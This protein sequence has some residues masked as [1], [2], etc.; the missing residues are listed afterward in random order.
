MGKLLQRVA[1][2]VFSA[3]FFIGCSYFSNLGVPG[4]GSWAERTL[5]QLTLREKIAQ[6][7]VY[8]MNLRFMNA[9]SDQW[10]EAVNLIE[11]DGVGGI[12][13]YRGEV[14]EALTTLNDLQQR[15]KVPMILDADLEYGLGWRVPGGT[16]IPYNMAVAATGNPEN[17]FLAGKITAIEGRAVGIQL[18]LVP[19]VDVNNNPD[20]PI[21]NTRSFG[22]DPAL[23]Q[24]F[25]TQ[26]IAGMHA[27]GMAAT[28]KHFPGHGDTGTD[29]HTRLATIPSDSTRLWDVELPPFQAAIDAGVDL[30]MIA[31]IQ[32][33]DYQPHAYTPATLSP[34]WIQDILR[35]KLNFNGIVVSDAMSMGGITQNYTRDYAIIEGINAGMD[36]ILQAHDFPYFVNVVEAAVLNGTISEARID[37]AALRILKLKETLGLHKNRYLDPDQTRQIYGTEENKQLANRIA[38]EALTLVK[39]D[40]QPVPLNLNEHDTLIVLDVYDSPYNHNLTTITRGLQWQNVPVKA[41]PVDAADD[42]AY[43]NTILE[44]IPENAPILVNA[45]CRYLMNKDRIFLPE[46]QTKFLQQV[47]AKSKRTILVSL[48]TPY[49]LQ[50]FPQVGAYIC[51]YGGSDQMQ[52][53]VVQALLGQNPVGGQLPV[54]IPGIAPMGSGI[55][56]P[57]NP[58]TFKRPGVETGLTLKRAMPYQVNADVSK[59]PDIIDSA[60]TDSAWPGGVFLAARAGKIF[61]HESFGYH[62]YEKNQPTRRGDI[63]DLASVT[64]VIATTSAVMKLVENG[65]LSLDDKVVK[66]LPEFTGPD[67]ANTKLKKTITIRNLLTH[68]A[69][70]PPFRRFY[71]MDVDVAARWDSVY[72]SAL[73]TVPGARTVYSDIGLILAAKTVEKITGMGLDEYVTEQIFEP[74]GMTST[75]FNPPASRLKRIVP[76]E[77]TELEGGLIQGHVHDENSYSLGGVT[78][79]AG[80]F[81]TA[82]DLAIFAQMMLNQGIYG[83]TRIFKPE[84]IELFTTPANLLAGS[85]RCLGWDSAEGVA[86]GGVYLGDQAFGHTGYTGTSIW[87]DPDHEMFTILLTNAVHPNRSYKYPNYFQW[88][89]LVHA[90]AYESFVDMTPNPRLQW[91][92]RWTKTR[93]MTK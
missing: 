57:A 68:T 90:A 78:G 26:Y 36:M 24:R 27:G 28:A 49:L 62:T 42:A 34:F 80:L 18:G 14:G 43:F 38:Q 85:S 17:A 58:V 56:L 25:A 48:G 52:R 33:P 44:Q 45:F 73:D 39:N 51:A 22:E 74:L 77:I 12:H 46:H 55:Q 79:H 84:T 76:T 8:H 1:L 3:I 5:K 81:S 50:D 65:D 64:K 13:I 35:K 83:K 87:I 60:V 47:F 93:S 88:R 41:F 6:M 75:Y 19:V 71:A 67:V 29:S 10:Q 61:Y 20:N 66:Y 40:G 59:I 70:L 31:H 72:Q 53:A 32:A 86:S 89:Q 69:G 15:S 82:H 37:S 4:T 23:V 2:L 7:M 91:S 92:P 9:E 16:D 63:F 54:T 30:V 11:S 21:I